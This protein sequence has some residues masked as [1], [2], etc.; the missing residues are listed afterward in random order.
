MAVRL[1]RMD[2][3]PAL[4]AIER[5]AAEAFRDSPHPWIADDGVTPAEAYPDAIAAGAVWVCETDGELDGFC[6]TEAF[7]GDALHVRELA[8]RH[9]RQGRGLGRA[10]MAAVIDDAAHRGLPAV[11]LT[12]FADVAW[13]APFYASLGFHALDPG[14]LD[15]RLRDDLAAEAAR[16]LINRVAMLLAL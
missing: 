13:N 2:D 3:I 8:V 10:L 9:D 7:P 5:S 16:G 4:P 12:T 14:R 15:D 1:A 11:T 6:L